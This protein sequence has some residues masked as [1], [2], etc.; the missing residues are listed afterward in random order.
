MDTKF[1]FLVIGLCSC[2]FQSQVG[3]N[4]SD[5]TASLD[6]NGNTRLR[7]AD[8]LPVSESVNKILVF[9]SEN[10]VHT[11]DLGRIFSRSPNGESIVKGVG[12][13]GFSVLSLNVL[14]GWQKVI[15]PNIEIDEG[16]NYNT[17]AQEFTAPETGIYNVYFFVEMA[18]I[19]SATTLGAGI[20]KKL[21]STGSVSLISEESFLN[22]S[23]L[24]INV[25]PPVRK[26][27]TIIKLNQ[28]DKITFGMKVPL[29]DIGLFTNSKASFAIWRMK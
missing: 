20:F 5:P 15:F 14:S 28:G 3:I 17:S 1:L 23:L 9:D 26:T 19:L 18:S 22:V 16:L 27:Q 2:L 8:T 11:T 6:V 12:G 13:A 21:A 24:G 29:T 10:V 7:M 25:S 4:T